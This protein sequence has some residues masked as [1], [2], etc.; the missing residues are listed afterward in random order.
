MVYEERK[1]LL[2]G[3]FLWEFDRSLIDKSIYSRIFV[4]DEKDFGIEV[5]I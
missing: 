1:T 3:T 4:L 5:R 2:L